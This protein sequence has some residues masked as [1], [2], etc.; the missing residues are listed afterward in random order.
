MSLSEGIDHNRH[1]FAKSEIKFNMFVE[2]FAKKH[3]E[4]HFK[5]E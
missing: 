2:Y 3:K 5:S 1:Q 4:L